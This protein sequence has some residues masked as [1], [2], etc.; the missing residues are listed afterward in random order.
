MVKV[1]V[2]V[3]GD[4]KGQD[5]VRDIQ[6]LTWGVCVMT[7]ENLLF[8]FVCLWQNMDGCTYTAE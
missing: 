5:I 6:Q 3:M 7:E 4:M 8:V 2:N 1:M